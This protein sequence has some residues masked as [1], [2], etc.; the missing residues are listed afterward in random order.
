ML[1]YLPTPASTIAPDH[2]HLFGLVYYISVLIFLVV[3]FVFVYFLFKYRSTKSPRGINYH[4]NNVLEFTWTL[5]PTI[6]FA[7]LGFYSDDL[8]HRMKYKTRVPNPD[9]E[10]D[11]LGQAY[12][13]HFRYPGADG[14]LGKRAAKF[15]EPTN[16]FGIDPNDPNGKDDIVLSNKFHLPVGKNVVVHLSSVDVLHSYF[17]PNFRVKQDAVP[18]MWVDVWFN[19]TRTGEFELACAELCGSGHYSMRGVLMMDS[20]QD[21]EKWM[22][23]QIKNKAA[24]IA[25]AQP[26]ADTQAPQED[27]KEVASEQKSEPKG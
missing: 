23:E 4:G 8:W 9:V 10:I 1:E 25:S 7:G 22:N 21:Y 6:L 15:I 3:N 16:V 20:Q 14:I 5:L 18:G 24:Q 26:A 11:V 17:L 13:W 12:M 2:D 19:G 27:K